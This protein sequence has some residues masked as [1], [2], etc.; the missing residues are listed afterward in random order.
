MSDKPYYYIT[1]RIIKTKH[2]KAKL[3]G[4]HLLDQR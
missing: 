4:M 3:F 1:L 2:E